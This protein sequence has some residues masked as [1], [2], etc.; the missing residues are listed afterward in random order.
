MTASMLFLDHAMTA[1]VAEGS[2]GRSSH[3]PPD[4]SCT[5][6]ILS[7]SAVSPALLY[8]HQQVAVMTIS[9]H[10]VT[11]RDVRLPADHVVSFPV[12]SLIRRV[13]FGTGDR[14]SILGSCDDWRVH[15]SSIHLNTHS[16]ISLMIPIGHPAGLGI[17]VQLIVGSIIQLVV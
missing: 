1:R 14:V 16:M 17:V 5:L 11:K 15:Q 13:C 2:S 7:S 10:V 6:R 9:A 8:R 3:S 12:Y 4:L